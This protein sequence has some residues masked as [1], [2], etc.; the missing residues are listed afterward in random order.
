MSIIGEFGA[1]AVGVDDVFLQPISC[2]AIGRICLLNAR[3]DGAP[4]CSC[5]TM[6]RERRFLTRSRAF[7]ADEVA[8]LTG[9]APC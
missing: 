4:A 7:A 1:V 9:R 8:A 6:G 2:V 3:A 5:S